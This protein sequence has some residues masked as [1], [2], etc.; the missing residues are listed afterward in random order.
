[1]DEPPDKFRL[2]VRMRPATLTTTWANAGML[3]S[4]NGGLEASIIGAV[5]T[6][7]IP[8]LRQFAR[9]PQ[10]TF[11]GFRKID[12]WYTHSSQSIRQGTGQRVAI[13]ASHWMFPEQIT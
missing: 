12:R 1:M 10:Q 5:D 7:V 2:D 13:W 4:R 8:A 11:L 6:V 9:S 3:Q